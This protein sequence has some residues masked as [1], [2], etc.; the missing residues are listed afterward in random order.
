MSN[1]TAH[2]T[3]SAHEILRF[4]LQQASMRV[5]HVGL[6]QDRIVISLRDDSPQKN[7]WEL[8]EVTGGP[9]RLARYPKLRPLSFDG[10][11]GNRFE[12]SITPG[13]CARVVATHRP[14][15]VAIVQNLVA[16]LIEQRASAS[17][18][19]EEHAAD[20]RLREIRQVASRLFPEDFPG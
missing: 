13:L 6:H 19:D 12:R 15:I 20:H 11:Y 10:P 14:A 2:A 1:V 17:G 5:R 8:M 3:L 7:L 18:L 9:V 16:R 4:S